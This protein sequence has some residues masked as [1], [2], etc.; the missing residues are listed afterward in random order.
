MVTYN[1]YQKVPLNSSSYFDEC[2]LKVNTTSN[3]S[4]TISM[5]TD[6]WLPEAG[7]F[8]AALAFAFESFVGTAL[9]ILVIVSLLRSSELRK[10][11][12]TPSIVSIAITDL[13]FSMFACTASATFFFVRDMPLPNGCQA[14][15]LI[16]YVLWMCSALN[17]FGIAILRFLMVHYPKK[18][19]KRIFKQASRVIPIM[20]WVVSFIWLLP[21]LIGRYGQFG[22]DCKLLT[23]RF[24]NQDVNG[25]N[26]NPEQ[27]YAVAIIVIG[28]IIFGLNLLTY[29]KITEHH[30]SILTTISTAEKKTMKR[31]LEK[32]RKLGRMVTLIIIS[33]F[34][35]YLPAVILRVVEPNSMTTKPNIFV[36]V[37]IFASSIGVIDPL[38]YIVFNQQYRDEVKSL[39]NDVS[40]FLS[41][42]RRNRCLGCTK[43]K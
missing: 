30:Q 16:Y 5:E 8:L 6:F 4:S 37:C 7:S 20:T 13:I 29:V 18:A 19:K 11:Y 28:L 15:S 17:L 1:E 12:L 35:V 42:S 3:M 31:I 2:W 10:G 38:V 27:T 25:Y 33:Y 40:S 43:S 36:T 39:V 32:E 23:C 21:T 24:V 9:N 22:L 41:L 26:S 14:F 34:I